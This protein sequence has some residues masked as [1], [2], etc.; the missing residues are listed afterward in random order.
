[1]AG[2]PP[3]QPAGWLRPA[4]R[5]RQPE[6]PGSPYAPYATGT[7]PT[8]FWLS[9]VC[10]FLFFPMGLVAV[11]YSI[12]VTRRSQSGD[13]LGAAKASHLARTWCL[14]TLVAFTVIAVVVGLT[15]AHV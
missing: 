4:W 9:L 2:F 10:T 6:Y 8:Y 11:A 13:V 5:S 15:G 14:A 1:V 3:R 7:P 12:L